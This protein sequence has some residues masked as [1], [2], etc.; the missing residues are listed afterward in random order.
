MLTLREDIAD[1]MGRLEDGEA[2]A[3]TLPHRSKYL[4]LVIDF[5]RRYLELHL[6]LVDEVERDFA[7]GEGDRR[8]LL[9]P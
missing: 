6:A 3:Q 5:L 4:L 2:T 8:A 9:S 7:V 1:L